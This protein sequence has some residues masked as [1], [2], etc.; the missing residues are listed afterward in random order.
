MTTEKQGTTG[1]VI[2]AD[3]LIHF[4]CHPLNG[5][6]LFLFLCLGVD[7]TCVLGVLFGCAVHCQ[8]RFQCN[9]LVF[10]TEN[11]IENAFKR[12]THIQTA[13]LEHNPK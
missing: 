8:L 7:Y 12:E 4:M 10:D 11:D 2:R 6:A 13:H 3:N 1:N 9:F 5:G